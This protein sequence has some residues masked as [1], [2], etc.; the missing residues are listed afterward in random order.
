MSL[1]RHIC[2]RPGLLSR[3]M[4]PD[5]DICRIFP[6]LLGKSASVRGGP[7]SVVRVGPPS[8][9][10]FFRAC[11]PALADRVPFSPMALPGLSDRVIRCSACFLLS[12]FRAACTPPLVTC[13]LLPP[14][15]LPLLLLLSRAPGSSS[16]FASSCRFVDVSCRQ[17]ARSHCGACGASPIMQHLIFDYL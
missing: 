11:Q 16:L 1:D 14:G 4:S 15:D 10:R 6:T 12:L 17:I 3:K 13:A 5:R 9:T 2:R 7:A 8:L